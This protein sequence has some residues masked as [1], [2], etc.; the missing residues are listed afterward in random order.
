MREIKFR[1][2]LETTCELLPWERISR[3]NTDWTLADLH[4]SNRVEFDQFTGLKDKNGKE[5]Y[6]G[7]II[8]DSNWWWGPGEVFFNLE[9]GDNTARYLVK[10]TKDKVITYNIWNG[11]D[12]KIIGNIYENPELLDA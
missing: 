12:V 5:I 10:N 8:A 11:K 7:D 2:W 4:N 6:E 1:V 9:N 3:E